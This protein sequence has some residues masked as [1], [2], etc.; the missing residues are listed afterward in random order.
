MTKVKF[1]PVQI[2]QAKKS[3]DALSYNTIRSTKLSKPI[4][5]LVFSNQLREIGDVFVK[6]DQKDRMNILTKKLAETLVSLKNLPIAGRI[7]SYLIKFNK[8]DRKLIEEYATNALII[9]KRLHDPVHTMARANDLKEVYKFTQPHS[10]KH[11]SVLY[12]E[13][14]ALNTIVRNYESSKRRFVSINTEMKPVENYEEQLAGIKIEIAETLIKRGDNSAAK[15]ELEGALEIYEKYGKG[16]NAEKA[17]NLL[18]K[19]G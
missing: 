8:G 17:E 12:D 4:N 15:L 7:Y 13:K 18:K 1:N 2:A 19:I 11:L 6:E 14:R 3:F 16:P 5:P 9:A 10:D